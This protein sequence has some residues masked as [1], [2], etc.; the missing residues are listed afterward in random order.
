VTAARPVRRRGPTRA[1]AADGRVLQSRGEGDPERRR[2]PARSR[3]TAN[4]GARLYAHPTTRTS[5]ARPCRR[6]ADGRSR[7]DRPRTSASSTRSHPRG[8]ET[9]LRRVRAD[10]HAARRARARARIDQ[11]SREDPAMPRRPLHSNLRRE[12]PASRCR[13]SPDRIRP[14]F[15]LRQKP[16]PQGQSRSRTPRCKRGPPRPPRTPRRNCSGLQSGRS[17]LFRILVGT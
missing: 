7:S 17:S 12:R 11:V 8:C 3:A 14:G 2:A 16:P 5:R 9:G 15:H 13:R 10:S 6:A 4:R 1:R